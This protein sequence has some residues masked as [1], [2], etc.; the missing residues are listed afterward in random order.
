MKEEDS[1][2]F[3]GKTACRMGAEFSETQ[4]KGHVPALVAE[5][6]LK[7]VLNYLRNVEIRKS[8]KSRSKG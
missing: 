1:T 5:S 4:V 8:Y 3:S 7:L 6:I 2:D